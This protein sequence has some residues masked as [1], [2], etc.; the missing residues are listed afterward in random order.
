M[1]NKQSQDTSRIDYIS[2]LVTDMLTETLTPS[3][4]AFAASHLFGVAQNAALLA[5]MRN[6]DVELSYIAGLLHD[7]YKFTANVVDRHAEDGAAFVKPLLQDSGLFSQK[8]VETVCGA[9]YFHSDKA[10][11]HLPMDEIL[12]DADVLNTVLSK[13]GRIVSARQA[14]RWEILCK[15]L[16]IL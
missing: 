15:E 11:R 14:A 9:I 10:H 1:N 4:L 5:G 16:A 3:R 8:E 13:G 6:Q 12:K 2:A 7:L